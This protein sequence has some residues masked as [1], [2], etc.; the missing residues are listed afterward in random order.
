MT[1]AVTAGMAGT[2]GV[3]PGATQA[4][5]PTGGDGA[6][7][8]IR[9]HPVAAY[10]ALALAGSWLYEIPFLLAQNGFG[11][12]PFRLPHLL[13]DLAPAFGPTLAA[14]VVTAATL[15]REGVRRF[16]RRYVQWRLD[17]RWYLLALAGYPTAALLTA[18]LILG[19]GPVHTLVLDWPILFSVYLSTLAATIF[20]GA[21]WEVPGWWG[22]ALPRLQPRLG[23]LRAAALVGLGFGVWHVPGAFVSGGASCPTCPPSGLTPGL[24]VSQIVGAIAVSVICTWVHNNVAGSLLILI[25]LKQSLNA[26]NQLMLVLVPDRPPGMFAGLPILVGALLLVALTRGRLSYH[27][28]AAAPPV[29][30]SPR[31]PALGSPSE[32]QAGWPAAGAQPTARAMAL[33]PTSDAGHQ[34]SDPRRTWTHPR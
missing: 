28:R 2:S 34:G 14:L 20:T 7:G 18:T 24:L 4:D 9:R 1:T 5:H 32:T 17:L 13:F 31:A 12:L 19:P 8:L 6:L 15:G 23:A 33:S 11:L 16:L 29:D 3:T 30:G 22:F 26:T 25:L 21:L 10:F 27:R